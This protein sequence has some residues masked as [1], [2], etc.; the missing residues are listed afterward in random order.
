M[1]RLEFETETIE[2]RSLARGRQLRLS[3]GGASMA[4]RVPTAQ[5]SQLRRCVK[6]GG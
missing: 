1:A 6:L 5:P 4:G 3:L 2:K